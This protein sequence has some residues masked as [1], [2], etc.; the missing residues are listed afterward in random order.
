MKEKVRI[1]VLV[2]GRGS[3]LQALIDGVEDGSLP[4]AEIVQVISSREEAFA[5]ERAKDAG[6]KS[7]AVSKEAFP[8]AA[9]RAKEILTALEAEKTDLVVLAGYMSIL[10]TGIIRKYEG[11]MINIHPSLIPKYCGKGF[12]GMKVH[13]AVIEAGEKVSGATV[14]FVAPYGIDMG[15]IILQREVP[16]EE[17]DDENTLAARVLETEHIMLPEAVRRFC[18]GKLSVKIQCENSTKK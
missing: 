8:D 11:R 13:R 15:E 18:D 14:H 10:D 3:N 17:G 16:V 4:D 12:Y 7:L 2:S 1:S 6:I 5:L 9:L